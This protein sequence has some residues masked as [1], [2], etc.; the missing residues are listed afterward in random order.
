MFGT[1]E[2]MVFIC[3]IIWAAVHLIKHFVPD[4]YQKSDELFNASVHRRI[5]AIEKHL[6]IK[7]EQK[8]VVSATEDEKK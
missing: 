7:T 3:V 8:V 1:F 5:D 4:Y 2:Y 6:G